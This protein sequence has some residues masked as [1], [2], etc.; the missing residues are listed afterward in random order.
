MSFAV[1]LLRIG[2]F[3]QSYQIY[4]HII[5]HSIYFLFNTDGIMTII[6]FYFWY[7]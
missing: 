7:G 3:H 5:V 6:L 2:Q 4:G 1:C